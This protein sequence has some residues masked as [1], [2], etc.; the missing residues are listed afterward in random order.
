M[1]ITRQIKDR[2]DQY[3]QRDPVTGCWQWQMSTN[4]NGYGRFKVGA[5]V[6]RAHR[7]SYHIHKG[8][9][10]EGMIVC[11]ACDN[12]GCV[13]P[14]HLWLGSNADNSADMLRKG[15]HRTAPQAGEMNNRATL[16]EAQA[17]EVI[18]LIAAGLSNKA[19]ATRYGVTHSSVSNIRRGKTW[20]RLRRPDDH[21]LF[22]RYGSLKAA[23]RAVF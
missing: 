23:A 12:P 11:H 7:V 5:G 4:H 9:I 1:R 15:R 21:P 8:P 10:P 19:I 17:R 3:H 2:F 22:E 18:S 6:E 16:T 14:D 20:T 13:N